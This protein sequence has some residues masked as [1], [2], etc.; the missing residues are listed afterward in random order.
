MITTKYIR[1]GISD[2]ANEEKTH[3]G[4]VNTAAVAGETR[5]GGFLCA[6]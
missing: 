6:T 5:G 1:I 3:H 4:L 2:E